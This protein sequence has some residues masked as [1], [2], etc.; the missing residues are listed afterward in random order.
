MSPVVK[1]LLENY[2][3]V[4][5]QCVELS[6]QGLNHIALYEL[7]NKEGMQR[8]FC[9]YLLQR[10]LPTDVYDEYVI[11]LRGEM[12]G[13]YEEYPYRELHEVKPDY[14]CPTMGDYPERVLRLMEFRLQWLKACK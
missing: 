13:R 7:I 11:Q 2:Q 9:F 6:E 1:E 4:Y 3:R 10:A 8:G 14:I 5:S 12:R